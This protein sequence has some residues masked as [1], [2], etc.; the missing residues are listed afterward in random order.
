MAALPLRRQALC[1][2]R[3]HAPGLLVPYTTGGDR[4]NYMLDFTVWID[5]GHASQDPLSL[6]TGVTGANDRDKQAK[7]S[8][9]DT[10]WVPAANSAGAWSRW[11]L[12]ETTD[13]WEAG[14]EMQSSLDRPSEVG[15]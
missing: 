11:A 9:A 3:N 8:T 4:R 7:V 13:P 15:V 1:Y 10:L 14:R 6:I 12:V 2:A 5:D